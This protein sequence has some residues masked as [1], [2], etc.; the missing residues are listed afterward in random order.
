VLNG[1]QILGNARLDVGGG[2]NE[3]ALNAAIG[4]DLWMRAGAGS[5]VMR[6]FDFGGLF[7]D[8]ATRV[9]LGDGTNGF[10]LQSTV[11]DGPVEV[12]SGR[13][14]DIVDLDLAVALQDSVAFALGDGNNRISLHQTT[15]AG[16]L[17]ITTGAGDDNVLVDS[18]V[19]A[20]QTLIDTG[21][22]TDVVGP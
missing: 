19:V 16:D 18:A 9:E 11:L 3:V 8:G 2:D 12:T 1:A 17:A 20:G 7:V 15:V 14:D 6:V 13:G 5:D 4:G 10:F 22:G 21:R